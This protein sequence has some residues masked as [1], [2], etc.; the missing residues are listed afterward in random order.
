MQQVTVNILA[1]MGA[2]TCDARSP[3]WWRARAPNYT[4]PAHLDDHLAVGRGHAQQRQ[5]RHVSG[6]A[7][8]TGG[9]VVAGVEVSTNG[10]ST[11]HPVTTMSAPQHQRDLELHLVS[12]RE[13]LGDDPVA[14]DR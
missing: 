2:A 8:D 11:W 14:G 12:G 6:T 10:G 7:T 13:R 3:T 4:W 9:G 1:D 5:H